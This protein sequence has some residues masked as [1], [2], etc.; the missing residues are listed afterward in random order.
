MPRSQKVFEGQIYSNSDGFQYEVIKYESATNVM[1]KWINCGTTQFCE[2]SDAFRG[3][4]KYLNSRT[5]FG[6]GYIG[7]GKFV[8]GGR[9]M[10]DWQQRISPILHRHWR[11]VLERTVSNREIKGYEDCKIVEEWHNFQN[12]AEWAIEAKNSEAREENGRLYALDKDMVKE[13][14]RIYCPEF[15]VFIPNEVNCFHTKKEV[16]DTGY[17]GVNR[18]VGKETSYKT[19]YIA[20]CNKGSVREYLGYYDTPEEAHEVYKMHKVMY[21]RELARKWEGKID[22]RV[23]EY[24]ENFVVK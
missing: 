20:R 8:P 14:N 7:Y 23:I 4:L 2:A 18:L 9:R 5:V 16:G 1:I 24:L 12:F 19:G 6:V 13:G 21:A 17:A 15:C 10:E 22:S 3:S 11:H